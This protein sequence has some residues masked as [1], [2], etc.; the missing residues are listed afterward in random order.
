M[1][2]LSI[3][4][5]QPRLKKEVERKSKTKR[6]LIQERREQNFNL[7]VSGANASKAKKSSPSSSGA[8]KPSSSKSS[9]ITPA[10]PAMP[11]PTTLT[12]SKSSGSETDRAAPKQSRRKQ[13]KAPNN[14]MISLAGAAPQVLK[15]SP[16]PMMNNNNLVEE[17]ILDDYDD[18]E[19]ENYDGSLTR[20][21]HQSN[22]NI[23]APPAD[24]LNSL[25]PPPS[26]SVAD[27]ESNPL[28][29]FLPKKKVSVDHLTPLKRPSS[30]RAR[31]VRADMIVQSVDFGALSR[32]KSSNENIV[33][34]KFE[35]SA[36]VAS[37]PPSDVLEASVTGSLLGQIK[38]LTPEQQR[39]LMAGLQNMSTSPQVSRPT[40]P[41]T[42]NTTAILPN[43]SIT[44]QRLPSTT[45]SSSA[46]S[47][48]K[49]A[50]P[51][52]FEPGFGST[53]NTPTK[54]QLEQND[55]L[56][57]SLE[58][59]SRFNTLRHPRSLK[60]SSSLATSPSNSPAAAAGMI[61]EISAPSPPRDSPEPS[62]NQV[63]RKKQAKSI[64][65]QIAEAE[66]HVIKANQFSSSDDSDNSDDEEVHFAISPK[67]SSPQQPID[68]MMRL[69]APLDASISL[70]NDMSV[71]NPA[72]PSS[73]P[74]P[75]PTLPAGQTLTFEILS[76]WGDPYY[77]GC[78]GIEIFDA[79]ANIIAIPDVH[80][81]VSAKPADVNCL[82]GSDNKDP[83]TTDKLFDS[84]CHT[85]D[86][87]HVWLAPWGL[88]KTVT[89]TVDLTKTKTLSMLRIWNYNKSRQQSYRGLRM[90]RI[91]L[92]GS[93]IF[94]G[95]IRKACGS[96][97]GPDECSDAILFTTDDEIIR[98]I[99]E[100]DETLYPEF[101][102]TGMYDVSATVVQ[103]IKKNMECDRP[104]TAG[105]PV[106]S[107]SAQ[108]FGTE[109]PVTRAGRDKEKKEA[110]E[111]DEPEVPEDDLDKKELEEML[112]LTLSPK[113]APLSDINDGD[114]ID[115]MIAAVT[116]GVISFSP[117][118]SSQTKVPETS[119]ASP[120]TS[121]TPP[122]HPTETF[123]CDGVTIRIHSTHEGQIDK[124]RMSLEASSASSSSKYVGLG[125][126][127]LIQWNGSDF[128]SIPLNSS[129]VDATP[130]D[131]Q[132][133]GYEGDK[134]TLSN[135]YDPSSAAVSIHDEAMWLVPDSVTGGISGADGSV[136]VR[137]N[138]GRV[139]ENFWGVEVWNYN[140]VGGSM[141]NNKYDKDVADEDSL[142]GANVVSL[143][144]KNYEGVNL[145]CAG[146]YCL[147][148]GPSC[149]S[150]DYKQ[151][152]SLAKPHAIEAEELL[153]SNK[154]QGLKALNM[155]GFK[156]CPTLRQDYETPFLPCGMLIKM[157]VHG[158]WGDPYYV[159]LDTFEIYDPYG[160]RVDISRVGAAPKGL[161]SIGMEG[162]GRTVE[163]L[164]LGSSTWLAPLAKSMVGGSDVAP[165]HEEEN[166]L[167]F[168]L[169]EPTHIG[170]IRIK[171][172]AKTVGRGV[173]DF[174]LWLD[175]MIVYRGYM[176]RGDKG[177]DGHKV[178]FCGEEKVMKEMGCG[179]GKGEGLAY[180]GTKVMDVACVDEGVV[181]VRSRYEGVPPD[182]CAEGVVADLSKRP[183]TMGGDDRRRR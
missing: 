30:A 18:E 181:V 123:A 154:G 169:D 26:S 176:D 137:V 43:Y 21:S 67:K 40:T 86:D 60:D 161:S 76:T 159:G 64:L 45:T 37:L 168:A 93:V 171:N 160:N 111:P 49:K 116:D 34:A 121:S 8:M 12:T 131:L 79:E 140:K 73:T 92:D 157:V 97:S 95:E 112:K 129:M 22:G 48:A 55:I 88:E 70:A 124:T 13:W 16:L 151:T 136:T 98:T 59:L 109:R 63:N 122:P 41:T 71:N 138:F 9:L 178:L 145:F 102:S 82:E 167:Y 81:N 38:N 152:L 106:E 165:G 147:R 107:L 126:I 162:D 20:K 77:V 166:V 150:F 65:E 39:K 28:P 27:D 5:F 153:K 144:L 75:I 29:D 17:D 173:R 115:D 23:S 114:D 87:M 132:S 32:K 11:L 133:L 53:D 35:R 120:S 74:P 172:Y 143:W 180:C 14:N 68:T 83:R 142:R 19:F 156:P 99:E 31:A 69:S 158:G 78:S 119:S 149:E 61:Q 10:S 104:R 182:P 110:I 134:R 96:L 179:G 7:H 62:P 177:G 4:L 56:E 163:G 44:P 51:R 130:K 58:S 170:G 25:L 3:L 127:R 72:P 85:C 164:G 183:M 174:S 50:T 175:G 2:F 141:E 24:S 155:M 80:N 135:L 105:S 128:E 94:E 101:R 57:Q 47:S 42:S 1:I 90:V 118:K 15:P 113:A 84:A 125:S 146:A 108:S 117:K 46:S 54:S 91:K 52:K 6:E 33:T 89:L 103:R 148:R 139:I 100:R 36:K 66:K